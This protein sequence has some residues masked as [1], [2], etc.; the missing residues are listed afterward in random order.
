[1]NRE[2]I[3]RCRIKLLTLLFITGLFLSGATA[4]PLAGELNLLVNFIGTKGESS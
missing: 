4:I 2:Q 1:M 3:L